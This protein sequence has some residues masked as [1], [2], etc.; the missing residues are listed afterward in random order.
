MDHDVD[1]QSVMQTLTHVALF[2]ATRWERQ[3]IRTALAEVASTTCEEKT[4][5]GLHRVVS[6]RG[7]CRISLIQTGMG[8]ESA[9]R[10]GRRLIEEAP[11]DLIVSTGFACALTRS[12]LADLLIGTE[13]VRIEPGLERPITV[14][15][16]ASY[17]TIALD[18]AK[19]AAL[20]VRAG[21]IVTMDRVV[22]TAR[23]KQAVA[24]SSGAVG[25]DMESAALGALAAERQ[26]PFL[27]VRTVSDLVE[28]E[29]PADFNLF[30]APRGWLRGILSLTRPSALWGLWRFKRQATVAAESLAAFFK[31]FFR[32]VN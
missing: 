21:R 9:A 32:L 25:L 16:S 27:I 17:Q 13:A 31:Q 24:Q 19:Q 18:V 29:L 22:G 26:I 2:V 14:P 3:A 10:A 1:R 30:L 11:C 23:Q 6:R 5:T 12:G 15:C 4:V 20:P 28:E 7:G 8:P